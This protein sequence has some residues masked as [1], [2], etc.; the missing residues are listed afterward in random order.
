MVKERTDRRG[1]AGRGFTLVELL[2]VIAIIGILIA[3]LLP[4]VQAA[5]EAARR[6]QCS[7]NLK[8]LALAMHNY[9]Q[10]HSV[11]PPGEVH[12]DGSRPGQPPDPGGWFPYPHCHWDGQVGMWSNLIFPQLEQQAA[13]DLLDFSARPQYASENNKKVVQMEFPFLVCPSDPY[14]GLTTDWGPGGKARTCHYFAVAGSNEWAVMPHPD[15]SSTAPYN[16]CSANDG[17]F[18]NDSN[19]R[20][21]DMLDGTSN[22]ALLCE[23]WGRSYARHQAPSGCAGESSRGMNLHSLVYFDTPPN[24]FV[25][26][27]NNC[28]PYKPNPWKPNSF[29]PGGVQVAFAD[30]S[31]HFVGDYVDLNVFKAI[32]TISGGEVVDASKLGR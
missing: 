1:R 4:A 31:V 16:Y 32:S 20:I 12:E 21:D 13:Y 10:A 15:G 9:H 29:H 26:P 2:V 28:P 11:L 22:T 5:R 14:R 18:W 3:L 17:P 27:T 25:V 8:Q 30:G 7:N 23:V 24:Y 6:M 19:T